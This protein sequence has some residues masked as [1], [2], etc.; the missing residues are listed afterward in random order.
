MPVSTAGVTRMRRLIPFHRGFDLER[1]LGEGE[2]GSRTAVPIWINFMR[3]ALRGQQLFQY[4]DEAGDRRP[5]ESHDVNDYLRAAMGE[6]FSAK[7]FRT[8]AGTLAAA[9]ALTPQA[10]HNHLAL[11]VDGQ[12]QVP[13]PAQPSS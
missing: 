12:Q 8:W 13:L 10:L 1:P 6:A 9:K 5:V 3:E 7:D 11:A 2:E 4:L